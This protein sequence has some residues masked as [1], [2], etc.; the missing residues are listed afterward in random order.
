M[1]QAT[2]CSLLSLEIRRLT[3]IQTEHPDPPV[4]EVPQWRLSIQWR[5]I[6]SGV[7]VS[8]YVISRPTLHVTLPQAKQELQDD[9]PIYQN[10]WR[11]AVY[12]FYPIK[13]FR[14]PRTGSISHPIHSRN[15][16]SVSNCTDHEPCI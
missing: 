13:I 10:G 12:S 2:H 6:S 5:H 15:T 4:V 14:Q 3:M 8:N 7:L 1:G 9:V 16:H 11:E